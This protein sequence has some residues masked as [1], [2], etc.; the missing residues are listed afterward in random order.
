MYRPKF[1]LN[2][3]IPLMDTLFRSPTPSGVAPTM[4]V[5]GGSG[6]ETSMLLPI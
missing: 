5:P 3:Q 4:S 1:M 6:I 2:L